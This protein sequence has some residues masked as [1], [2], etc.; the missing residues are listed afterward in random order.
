MTRDNREDTTPRVSVIV[1]AYNAEKTIGEALASVFAQTYRDFEVI[2][3]DDGSKDETRAVLARYGSD[4]TCVEQANAG[5]GRARNAGIQRA[6][7]ELVAFL[8]ADD[9]WLPEKL[10]RQVEYFDEFPATGLL[11]AGAYL[12]SRNGAHVVSLKNPAT[13]P[14]GCAAPLSPPSHLFCEIFETDVEIRTLTVMVRRSVFEDVGGFDER[15]EMHVEDWDLWLRIAARYPIGYLSCPLAVHRDGGIMSAALEKTYAGQMLVI[16][17]SLGEYRRQC[18]ASNRNAAAGLRKPL[19]RIAWELGQAHF[20]RTELRE[21]RRAFRTALR[22]NPWDARTRVYHLASRLPAGAIHRLRGMKR[23]R[24]AA[25]TGLRPVGL[26][27]GVAAFRGSHLPT[28]D[29]RWPERFRQRVIDPVRRVDDLLDAFRGRPRRILFEVASPSSFAA[30]EPVSRRLR[31]DPRVEIYFTAPASGWSAETLFQSAGIFDR[32]ITPSQAVWMKLDACLTA[33]SGQATRLRRCSLRVHLLDD[34]AVEDPDEAANAI[35]PAARFDVVLFPNRGRLDRYVADRLVDPRAALLVGRPRT[36]RLVNG[37]LDATAIATVLGLQPNVP[38]VLY[39][40]SSHS[41]NEA[42]DE[43]VIRRLADARF[44]V[45]VIPCS[46]SAGITGLTSRIGAA[47]NDAPSSRDGRSSGRVQ[48][49][50]T[51]D[52]MPYLMAADALVTDVPSFGFDY[53]LLNRPIVVIE[54][55]SGERVSGPMRMLRSVAEVATSPDDVQGAIGRQLADPLVH[56]HDRR[57]VAN[58]MFYR[59]GSATDR[60]VAALY[61]AVGLDPLIATP[62]GSD[63]IGAIARAARRKAS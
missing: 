36:D 32:V 35:H 13:V 54:T 30:V 51:A 58:A 1:P 47:T 49:I 59:P 16:Q 17:Q 23:H 60:A 61:E 37:S 63:V 10:A 12:D 50:D 15:R 55:T 41:S 11:H 52:A 4:I 20:E 56:A 14:A 22:A 7:G 46:D 43:A 44:N 25:P 5:P 48:V 31:L 45:L 24:V 2:V 42:L 40:T 29:K 26:R 3:V 62:A 8:D 27:Q 39:A 53:A 18:A 28:G 9:V 21:A 38:T 57:H 6:R 33:D 34:V 19:S